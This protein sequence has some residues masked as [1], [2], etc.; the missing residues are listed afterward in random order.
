MTQRKSIAG[1]TVAEGS[2][3]IE[4]VEQAYSRLGMFDPFI[5]AVMTK[6]ERK[7]MKEKF[8]AMTNGH[9]VVYSEQFLQPLTLEQIYGLVL[10]ESMHVILMHMWFRGDRDPALWN[11]ANDAIINCLIRERGRSGAVSID[12]PPGGVELSWV[13][14]DMTS[15]EV[16]EKLRQNPPPQNGGGKGKGK[17]KGKGQAQGGSGSGDD[18]DDGDGGPNA[19]GFDGTGDLEDAPDEGRMA[20]MQATIQAAAKM[21]RDCGQGS[22][23]IDRVL[24]GLKPPKVRWQDALRNMLT[25]SARADYSYNRPSRRFLSSGLYLPSLHTPA[26]GGL[27]IGFDTSGSMGPEQ[28]DQIASEIRAIADDLQ[29]A[30]IEVVYCDYDVTRVE[31]FE[32]EDMLQLKPLGGGGT[33][34]QPVFEHAAKSGHHYAGMVYFTDMEGNLDECVEPE[35]PTLWANIGYREYAPPFGDA[36]KVDL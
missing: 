21:V 13:K 29:P 27:L 32:R 4:R 16:Y 5:A 28:C 24:G 8:T 35:F 36:L 20:D 15:D 12:L 9:V 31:M 19:G 17:G 11:Y 30:F 6:V 34:F 7:V 10:H 14:P 18:G 22:A 25:E 26:M 1:L 33:R 3:Q 2:P 23:L